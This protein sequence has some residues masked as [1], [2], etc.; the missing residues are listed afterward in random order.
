MHFDALRLVALREGDM[1][2]DTA[3]ALACSAASLEPPRN[4]ANGHRSISD[5]QAHLPTL[6]TRTIT[7]IRSHG[8]TGT[9][10]IKQCYG[11]HAMQE[12]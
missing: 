12:K 2:E 5:E 3:A 1:I 4:P 10:P 11:F 8:H 6:V 7:D 9:V